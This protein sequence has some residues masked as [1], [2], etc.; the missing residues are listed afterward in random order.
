V[1]E[2]LT[3]LVTRVE[4]LNLAGNMLWP[5]L[6]RDFRAFPVSRHEWL[7]VTTDVFLMRYISVVDCALLLVNEI[8]EFGLDH[9]AC[10]LGNFRKRVC[11]PEW[12]DS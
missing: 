2:A 4:S 7:T 1:N 6:P 10:T 9:Q 3:R 5:E 12:A 8:F 11:R